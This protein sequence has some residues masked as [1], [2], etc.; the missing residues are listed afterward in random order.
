MRNYIIGKMEGNNE[1]NKYI[2]DEVNLSRLSR[3]FLLSV[4][5]FLIF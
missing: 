1:Y 3:K 5:N 4:N 2:P